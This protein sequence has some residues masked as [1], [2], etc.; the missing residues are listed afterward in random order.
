MRVV[1]VGECTIDRYLDAG[2]EHVGGISLNFAVN[3]S[4]A[5]AQQVGLVSCTG[6]DAAAEAVRRRLAAAGID[7]SHLHALP[8][9]TASQNIRLADGGERIFPPGGYDAGVLSSYRLQPPDIDFLRGAD[10]VAVPCFRQIAHLFMPI[11]R[12]GDLGTLR[13]ADLLDGAELDA[14]QD[15]DAVQDSHGLASVASAPALTQDPNRRPVAVPDESNRHSSTDA[16]TAHNLE[17]I[18]PLLD[19][20]DVLFISGNDEAA[21]RLLPWS[22]R[23]RSVL[24]VTHGAGGSSA[25]V[26]GVRHVAPAEAVPL[27]ERIDTTGCGDAFQAAFTVD[28]FRNRNV[29]SALREGAR[30]AAVVIRHLGATS[31][32]T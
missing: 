19:A 2:V 24:V 15:S 30:R 18:V 12:Q 13:V 3:A 14:I 5:G 10:V 11:L 1:A 4:R 22:R 16:R 6:T 29:R 27:H 7:A 8:G 21:E 23:T 32:E 20:F 31:D 25:L 28:Y 26:N 17:G 9:R